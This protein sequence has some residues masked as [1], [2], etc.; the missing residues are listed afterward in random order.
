MKKTIVNILDDIDGSVGAETVIFSY[1]GV[2]YE[3]D[4]SPAHVAAFDTAIGRFL[5]R[6]RRTGRDHLSVPYRP[7][8]RTAAD[9]GTDAAIRD[10]ARRER[11]DIVVNSRGRI[12]ESIVE[13]YRNRHRDIPPHLQPPAPPVKATATKVPAK[14]TPATK[15]AP[16]SNGNHTR[17]VPTVA[18]TPAGEPAAPVPARRGRSAARGAA[19]RQSR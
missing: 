12:K 17:P 3:I 19:V 8:A 5:D 14:K 10:W 7:A 9:S 18:F 16:A 15:A 2:R 13:A 4:L 11:P 6:A 1:R